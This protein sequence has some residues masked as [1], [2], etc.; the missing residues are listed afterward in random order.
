MDDADEMDHGE[1]I[2]EEEGQDEGRYNGGE[3]EDDQRYFR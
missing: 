3:D 1:D 2:G